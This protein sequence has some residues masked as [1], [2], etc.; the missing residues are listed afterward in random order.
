MIGPS[1][2]VWNNR[3]ARIQLSMKRESLYELVDRRS[4]GHGSG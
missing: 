1:M 4:L 2:A 3:A